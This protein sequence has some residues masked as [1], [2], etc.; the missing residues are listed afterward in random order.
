MGGTFL[1]NTAD[2]P[3]D[4]PDIKSAPFSLQLLDGDVQFRLPQDLLDQL[5]RA[6]PGLG[7]SR[8]V[9]KVSAKAEMAHSWYNPNTYSRNNENGVAMVDSF[10]SVAAIVGV[11]LDCLNWFPSSIRA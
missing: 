8:G 5:T 7:H 10:E 11:S 1:D 2:T 9:L 6:V 3:Q 4:T